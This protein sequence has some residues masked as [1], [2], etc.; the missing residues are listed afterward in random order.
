MEWLVEVSRDVS[1]CFSWILMPDVASTVVAL[2]LGHI[3]DTDGVTT[4]SQT[5]QIEW[6]QVALLP[7]PSHTVPTHTD[8]IDTSIRY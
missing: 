6:H 8:N 2:Q 1:R 7:T 4:G 3:S 5:T